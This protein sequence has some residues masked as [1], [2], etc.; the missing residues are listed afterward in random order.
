MVAD[1]G[2]TN[3]SSVEI[4]SIH[5]LTYKVTRPF[6]YFVCLLIVRQYAM[7]LIAT[8]GFG[9]RLSWKLDKSSSD[10]MSFGEAMEI[11]VD[12]HIL[13]L[14]LPKW[15]YSLP[16][17]RRVY[18]ASISH[19][20]LRLYRFRDAARAY[21]TLLSFMQN[22]IDTS[23][24]GLSSGAPIQNDILSL[25]IESNE[26]ENKLTMDDSEIVRSTFSKSPFSY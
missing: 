12:S 14:V 8:C 20:R 21:K 15:A 10:E 6:H 19:S 22:L 23:R 13:L 25:M 2:W 16:V 24:S 26:N 11:I 5:D 4:P 3:K 18:T 17:K 9:H 1:E 7:I